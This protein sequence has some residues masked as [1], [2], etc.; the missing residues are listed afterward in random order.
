MNHAGLS[1]DLTRSFPNRTGIRFECRYGHPQHADVA[2][3]HNISKAISGLAV[4]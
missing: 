2:A 4:A 3:A 1:R